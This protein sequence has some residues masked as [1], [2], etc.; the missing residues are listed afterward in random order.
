MNKKSG[1][2]W[3]LGMFV[4]I[5][6]VAF[7]STIYFVGKQK[8]IFG[9][10]F[11]LNSRFKNVS[12]LEV[13]NNVLFSGI[14]VGTV[15]EIQLVTDTSVVVRLLIQKDVQKF[16]KSDAVASIGSDG[17]M[18]DKVLTI[19]PGSNSKT[20]VKDNASIKSIQAI[21][22]D[23]IMRS[24]KVSM[25]N[26]TVITNELA[27]FTYKMNNGNGA[28]SKLITDEKFANSL[29]KTLTNLQTGSKGLSENM[30]AAKH[31]FL[32]KGFF[33][34]KKRAEEK[35]LKELEKA[36]ENQEKNEVVK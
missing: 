29:T 35:R 22:M 6:L 21:E 5:G 31:N 32:L 4:L 19:S 10:T 12:G 20:I 13:G 8:N 30:E 28:L 14:N 9:S 15:S 36:K 1:S 11:T 16:I 24:I 27:E 18:G 23:E 3:K 26:A 2:T 17:L 25:D 7:T 33:N 34:K